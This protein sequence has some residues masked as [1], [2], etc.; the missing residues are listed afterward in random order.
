MAGDHSPREG[1][2]RKQTVLKPLSFERGAFTLREKLLTRIW[3]ALALVL[4]L[5][6]VS[7][8]PEVLAGTVAEGD[9]LSARYSSARQVTDEAGR[10]VRLPEHI[11]RIISL[12]PNLTEIIYALG[13][14]NRLVGVTD[15][16]DFPEA[17]RSKPRVGSVL[18]PSVEQIVA[19]KPDLVL[20]T[21]AGNRAESVATL[22]KLGI[23]VYAT[24]PR[25]V[26]EILTSILHLG[27]V[28]GENQAALRL[29]SDLRHRLDALGQRLA[30]QNPLGDTNHF[31]LGGLA[32]ASLPQSNRG[33]PHVLFVVWEEPLIS[34]GRESFLT[35]AIARAGGQSITASFTAAWPRISL[36]AA[37]QEQPDFLIFAYHGAPAEKAAEL[38]AR[39]A[40]WKRKPGWREFRAVRQGKVILVSDTINRPSPRLFDA[41]E[42]L[43]RALHPEVF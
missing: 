33:L 4:V 5:L 39:L 41:I 42:E 31:G 8:R 32:G 23:P 43:A 10:N 16:C 21:V 12:A 36:E 9:G 34:A 2:R 22:E 1:V 19:L 6:A 18:S 20:A 17:A 14:E 27:D 11:E 40:E 35:D 26:D 24:N 28:L 13:A 38:S 7:A 3:L 15:Y 30:R 37:L 25:T 29:A